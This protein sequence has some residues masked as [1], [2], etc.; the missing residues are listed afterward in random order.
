MA[1]KK[2]FAIIGASNFSLSVLKT[3][4]DKRQNVTVF[5]YDQDRLDL[6]L[7]EFDTVDAIVL[8][9]TNKIGLA[10]NGINAYDGVIVGFGS[11]IEASMMTI[12]NL[13]DLECNNIIV[14]ARDEK[15][16]RILLALG[17]TENQI[18]LPDVIA[19]KII[20]T[21][22]VFDIDMDIDVQSIDDDFLST[23]LTVTNLDIIGKTLQ[24]AGLST[25]KDF[26]IIQIRRKGKTLLPDD[27]TVI[28]AEDD[29]V[30][31]AKTTV[32]NGLAEK[33]VGDGLDAMDH[34]YVDFDDLVDE[35]TK[36]EEVMK[37]VVF[38]DDIDQMER[39][40]S[41]LKK[42]KDKEKTIKDKIFDEKTNMD[43]IFEIDDNF[44]I[45]DE[46]IFK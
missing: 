8:D 16:K 44:T 21:R 13:L 31:F 30:V 2:S 37:E 28:K 39:T 6:Y 12:L 5:D 17:L 9:S 18:V 3:L 35:K 15:H 41:S 23:T 20:G 7:S 19:G 25:T 1:K 38:D 26:N 40:E 10:K 14:K 32:I 34:A 29:V 27:Y 42:K 24:E 4:I 43:D 33:I 36:Q 45:K 11:N 46:D 22:A